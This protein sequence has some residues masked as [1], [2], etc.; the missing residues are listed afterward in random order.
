M[1]TLHTPPDAHEAHRQWGANCGPCAI[2]ALLG[3]S[4]AEV[5]P[6]LDGFSRRRYMN[7]THVRAALE[8]LGQRVTRTRKGAYPAREGCCWPQRGL[9]FIQ[10]SGEWDRAPV[11][12]QYK[13][14]HWIATVR[15]DNHRQVYD[16]SA[17]GWL[18]FSGWLD[19]V[20][21]YLCNDHRATD[22]WVRSGL[23]VG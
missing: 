13:H 3:K 1:T 14:T 12:V 18:S 11:A 23:E 17:E 6:H 20:L 16:V 9:A 4:L 7:P 5:R 22:W 8:S 15:I 10:F 2:A 19:G 21:P